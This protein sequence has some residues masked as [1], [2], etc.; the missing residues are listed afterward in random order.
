MPVNTRQKCVR[1]GELAATVVVP[2][3][4]KLA[5]EML[6][7]AMQGGETPPE[8]SLTVPASFP[9]IKELVR[10]SGKKNP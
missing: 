8:P 3:N 1:S 9:S 7:A 6:V 10:A 5:I 2:T 4:T